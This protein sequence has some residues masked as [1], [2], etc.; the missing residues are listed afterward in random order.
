MTH[1][2]KCFF[3]TRSQKAEIQD[4]SIQ[5]KALKFIQDSLVVLKID[6]DV[7][8]YH[9][10]FRNN[11]NQKSWTLN[12]KKKTELDLMLTSFIERYLTTH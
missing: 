8:F 3:Q 7:L 10:K 2:R 9:K 5:T 4:L 11:N 12:K 1:S 6:K